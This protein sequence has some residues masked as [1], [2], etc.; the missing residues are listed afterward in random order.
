LRALRPRHRLALATN[1]ADSGAALVRG[2]LARAGLDGFFDHLFVSSELGVEKPDPR[3]FAA[4]LSGLR[5][6]P[7]QVVLVGDGYVDDVRGACAAGMKTVW[8]TPPDTQ[9]PAG[10]VV[11]DARIATLAELSAAVARLAAGG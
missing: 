2:A 3:F 10:D 8:L 6:A 7:E 9:P 11:H 1:A 4:V 5:L